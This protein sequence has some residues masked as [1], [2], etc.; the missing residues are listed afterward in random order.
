MML[1]FERNGRVI[2]QPDKGLGTFGQ[3]SPYLFTPRRLKFTP[4]AK[5]IRDQ[6]RMI[7]D[8]T[9]SYLGEAE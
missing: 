2:I 4:T 5:T 3:I 1:V 8:N 6:I 7:T 9:G